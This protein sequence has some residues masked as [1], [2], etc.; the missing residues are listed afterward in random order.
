LEGRAIAGF[1]RIGQVCG[2]I[3]DPSFNARNMACQRLPTRLTG[4]PRFIGV[5]GRT[6]T[7]GAPTPGVTTARATGR[8]RSTTPG[9]TTHPTG[10][11]TY[12]Q[13]TTA[14]ACSVLAATNPVISSAD[15]AIESFILASSIRNL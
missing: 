1:K 2:R 5:P 4:P 7:P 8:G 15:N 12:W 10:Y 11:A 14:L 9:L 13:Y 6:P 3:H